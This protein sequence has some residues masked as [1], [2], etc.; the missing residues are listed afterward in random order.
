[1]TKKLLFVCVIVCVVAM[2]ALAADAITGKWVY[3][4][5]GRQG[6]TP[7]QTTLD[8][9]ASGTTLTG[10][11]TAPA[12]GGRGGGG[13][14]APAT[15]PAPVATPITNGKVDGNNISFD[16]VRETQAGSMTTKYA[17][18][19]AGAELQLKITSNRGGQDTTVDAV[20]KRAAN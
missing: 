14:A 10:T 12:M 17:G 5:A 19:V 13:A 2:V 20:A 4:Q 11:V 3:E 9:K 16:V 18:T 15:P 8:L 7:R 6:G 1:M